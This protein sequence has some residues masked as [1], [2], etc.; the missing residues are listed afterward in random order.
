M[1][2]WPEIYRANQ[3]VIGNNPNLLRVGMVLKIPKL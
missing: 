3:A 1:Q 2:Q